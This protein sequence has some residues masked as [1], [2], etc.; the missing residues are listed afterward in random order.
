MIKVAVHKANPATAGQINLCGESAAFTD[1]A[2]IVA[3]CFFKFALPRSIQFE[4]GN[5]NRIRPTLWRPDAIF[6]DCS[7]ACI[8]SIVSRTSGGSAD[9]GFVRVNNPLPLENLR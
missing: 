2:M 3:R 1:P 6:G 9:Y 7:E 5:T 4:A 8:D